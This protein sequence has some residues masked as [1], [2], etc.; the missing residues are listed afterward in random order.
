MLFHVLSA[1][2]LLFINTVSAFSVQSTVLVIAKDTASSYSATSG[3]TAYGIPYQVLTVPSTGAALPQLSTASGDGNFGGIVI[4]SEVSYDYNGQFSSALTP[5]QWTSLFDY[6]TSFGVRMTRIDVYPG[7]EFGTAPASTISPG[8]C[9]NGVEQ[10]ISI[11]NSTGFAQAGMKIGATMSTKGLYHYPAVIANSSIATTIAKFGPS[12]I[13]TGDTTAAVINNIGGREQMAWFIGWAADWSPTSTYLEHAWITWMTRG[14]YVGFRRVYF[15]TQVDDMFLQTSLY[16]PADVNFRVTPADLDGHVAWSA[17]L[18]AKLSPGSKYFTEVGHNGNGNIEASIGSDKAAICNP[19]SAIEY[20]EQI[21]TPLEFQKPLGSGEDIW[22][23]E[24]KTYT[25]SRACTDLDPLQKW[26]T[27]PANR[28]VFAHVTHTFSH[29]GLNNATYADTSKEISFNKAWIAQIGIDK[30]LHWSSTGLI[31]PAITGMHNGDAIRAW[32]DNGIVNG[33]GDNTRPVLMNAEHEHWPLISTVEGN[34]YAGFQITPRWAT[35]IYYN[36]DLPACTVAEWI[37][38]SAGAGGIQELLVN[39]VQ[40][41][42]KHLLSLHHDPFMFHQ[43]NMRWADVAEVPVNGVTA[44]YSLLMMWV[45]SVTQEMMRLVEWP[46]V[47]LK[48][49]DIAASFASRMARDNC[50]PNVAMIYGPSNTTKTIVGVTVTTTGN[51]CGAEIPVTLPGPV[52]ATQARTGRSEQLGSDPL[53]IWL[54]M[55]GSP[56]MLMLQKPIIL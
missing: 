3:L 54:K 13:F 7:A 51:V 29:A 30:A 4:L 48:H 39:A 23:L 40:V 20:D 10:L 38:T 26:W 1:S 37:A 41:N 46:M 5:A 2:A 12:G 56:V 49:D 33:V 14:L 19:Q 8:C 42:S 6:Q 43:A 44:K 25:W 15:S 11:S 45:E 36:C 53:T 55:T 50:S 21:D 31:P 22:P 28:D 16:L 52:I 34:G 35:T 9:E 17:A 27:N 24:P 32:M 18:N 47:S